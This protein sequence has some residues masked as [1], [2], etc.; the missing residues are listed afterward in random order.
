GVCG[1][2]HRTVQF[3]VRVD[4]D[5]VFTF[6]PLQGQTAASLR[7]RYPNVP[8]DLSSMAYLEGGR[9][10]VRSRAFV[11]AAKHLPMPWRLLYALRWVPAP[12]LDLGYRVIAATRYRL[13]G[14]Y[15][16]C[17]IPSPEQRQ[18]FLP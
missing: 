6:A 16:Q 12:I 15:D 17:D 14:K 11:M 2:C 5:R 13:F 10:Y 8:T 18:R 7:S 4:R 1:L 9:L 3:L